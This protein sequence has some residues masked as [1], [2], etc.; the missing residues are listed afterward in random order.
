MKKNIVTEKK[1]STTEVPKD[2]I[3]KIWQKIQQKIQWYTEENLSL[4][5]KSRKYNRLLGI[6]E[7]ENRENTRKIQYF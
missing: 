4:Q 6:P 2:K 7:G 1:K 5:G 3:K